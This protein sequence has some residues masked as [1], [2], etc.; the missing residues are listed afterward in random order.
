MTIGECWEPRNDPLLKGKTKQ[1]NI[2][3]ELHFKNQNG[4]TKS[5]VGTQSPDLVSINFNLF[6]HGIG[7]MFS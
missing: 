6:L 3:K 4:R 2:L 1:N 7:A 5:C